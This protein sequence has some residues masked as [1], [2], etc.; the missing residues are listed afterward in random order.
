MTVLDLIHSSLRLIGQL[1]PG[2]KASTSET[3]DALLILN[4]MLDSW[5]T[6]G[7]TVFQTG[8]DVYSWTAEAASKTIGPGG[9]FSTTEPLA[10]GAEFGYLETTLNREIPLEALTEDKWRKIEHKSRAGFPE[11]IH[12][13]K[14]YP[15]ATLYLWPIPPAAGSLIVYPWLTLSEF[16]NLAQVVSFPR[17]YADAIRYNLAIHLGEEWG[18]PV[19]GRVE[20]MAAN[21][22][23]V[24]KSRNLEAIESGVDPALV[25]PRRGSINYG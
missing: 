8:R 25:A 14:A 12:N 10:I 1:G 6:E 23:G 3:T 16:N 9:D 24:V 7:L 19:S 22:L 15:V 13:N 21:K 2:R 5:G 18:R 20:R 4:S 17:G 11:G